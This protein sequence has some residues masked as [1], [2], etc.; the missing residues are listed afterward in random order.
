MEKVAWKC[1]NCGKVTFYPGLDPKTPGIEIRE[2]TRCF[3]CFSKDPQWRPTPLMVK[4]A[5]H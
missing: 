2:T 1:V 3:S 4:R 5:T